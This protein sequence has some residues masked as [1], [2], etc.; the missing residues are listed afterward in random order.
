MKYTLYTLLENNLVKIPLIQRDYAQG[1]ESEKDLR[2]SF[3]TKIQ[4]ILNEDTEKLNLD[5]VYGYTEKTSQ[6]KNDFIPLDGQQRLTTLWLLHWYFAS[7]EG[8]LIKEEETNEIKTILLNF[9]YETRI[10]SKRF[11]ENLVNNPISNL[12]KIESIK[13]EI[14]DSSWFMTSWK[15]DPTIIAMLNMLETIHSSLADSENVWD[16]LTLNE[17]ITFDYIDIKSDEFKLTDELYIKMNSRGKPLTPFENFKAIFSQLLNDDKTNYFKER[18]DF[19]GSKINYQQYFAFNIDGKWVDLFWNYRKVSDKGLDENI[20]NFFY[21][22]AEMLHYKKNK[23][24]NFIKNFESLKTVY[25]HKEN[26]DFLF[27]SLDF[28]SSVN[29]IDSFFSELFC[30]NEYVIGKVKLFDDNTTDLFLRAFT[31]NQ[32][33]VKQRVL[34]YGV[35]EFCIETK[36]LF[37]DKKLK[38]FIRILRNLLSR[39]RQVNTKKRIEYTSNLRLPNFFDYSKFIDELVKLI[40]TNQN[41]NVFQLFTENKLKGFTKEAFDAE[42]SK[43]VSILK[44]NKEE[45]NIIK[46]EEHFYLEGISDNFEIEAVNIEKYV[47]AFY[48]IWELKE[49]N[50]SLLVRALLTHGDFSVITHDYSSLGIIRYFGSKEYWNRIL[51][52]TDKIEQVAIKSIINSFLKEYINLP[53]K[54]I[55]DKLN[56]MIMNFKPIVKDWIYYFVKYNEFTSTYSERFNLFTWKDSNG[57]NINSLGNSGIQPLASYHL[58]P[59]LITINSRLTKQKGL[60]LYMGRY[61]EDLSFLRLLKDI[62][63]YCSDEGY[64]IYNIDK[65]KEFNSLVKNF[66]LVKASNYYVLKESITKDK[67]EIAIDFCQEVLKK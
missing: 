24:E 9:T 48:E 35:L 49:T 34:L 47:E 37:P 1:R 57:F 45:E 63:I 8:K 32:F 15:N 7:K 67:I 26:V 56:K 58:N 3:I 16:K 6:G 29:G 5:F 31:D 55:T 62:D 23:D 66:K 4:K 53:E 17:L 50:N 39:I 60:T 59:Y 21:Y 18:I 36:S 25:A 13:E 22:V 33:D 14:I 40:K 12:D 38:D 41:K 46:L 65:H 52:T 30:N 27:N 61:T 11:C 42:K 28:L 2:N 10:S 44:N 43:I 20:L 54:T 64:D 19:K 51:S